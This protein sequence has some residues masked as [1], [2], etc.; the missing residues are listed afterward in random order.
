MRTII[1][2]IYCLVLTSFSTNKSACPTNLDEN[3]IQYLE[4]DI[5]KYNGKV[6]AFDAVV[7]EIKVG[8]VNKPFYKVMLGKEHLWVGGH[9]QMGDVK[10]RSSY[11]IL[12]L[13]C[14]WTDDK[15]NEKYNDKNYFIISLAHIDME[16]KMASVFPQA[17]SAFDTWTKGEIPNIPKK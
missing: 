4:K 6:V 15:L 7:S 10:V 11:R 3:E 16:T 1:L 13:I 8:N 17:K 2:I 5:N 14:L 9:G 12:G